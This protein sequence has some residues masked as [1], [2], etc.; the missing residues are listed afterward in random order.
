MNILVP[1][2]SVLLVLVIVS[3]YMVMSR[4][5]LV[6]GFSQF[7]GILL[8]KNGFAEIIVK[9]IPLLLV[10]LGLAIAYECNAVNIGAEGQ[11]II[12]SIAAVWIAI[13]FKDLSSFLIIPLIIAFSFLIGGLWGGFAGALKAKFGINE[14]I[15]TI[16]MNYVAA[17]LLQYLMMGPMAG[18]GGVWPRSEIITPAAWLPKLISETRLHAGILI[19]PLFAVFVW[20]LLSKTVLGYKIRAVGANPKGA[21]FGGIN[22]PKILL[23]AMIFSGGFAG[24]AGS[25]EVMGI[26][27]C[28][29]PAISAGYGY[30]GI[31]VAWL[32]RLNP[33]GVIIATFG[34]STIMVGLENM[35]G[36]VALP[37]D[38]IWVVI[39]LIFVFVMVGELLVRYKIKRT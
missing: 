19:V 25:I 12:G 20:V 3:I 6:I 39:G 33:I 18:G 4:V 14:V 37:K 27:H 5:N 28:F 21:R 10:S 30:T 8:T 22:P 31:A 35:L 38:L 13:V 32:G 7:F 17:Y 24:V 34:F 11:I 2:V 29:L 15:V 36:A 9:A 16:M 26:H 1:I 23:I